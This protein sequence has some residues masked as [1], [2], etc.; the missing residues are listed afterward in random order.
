ME[1]RS[2]RLN[3]F[4][5]ARCSR[6]NSDTW[7]TGWDMAFKRTNGDWWKKSKGQSNLCPNSIARTQ[8]PL[9]ITH[10][11]GPQGIAHWDTTHL[12]GV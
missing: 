12:R 6:G 10:Q 3:I 1:L 8:K 2:M 7:Y 11:S 4:W 9:N 5:I